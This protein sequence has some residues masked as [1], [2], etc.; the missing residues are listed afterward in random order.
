MLL[1]Q[2]MASRRQPRHPK[3]TGSLPFFPLTLNIIS[4]YDQHHLFFFPYYR[5][6]GVSVCTE[7]ACVNAYG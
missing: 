4:R 6:A 2:S 3:Y 7:A 1:G 5:I